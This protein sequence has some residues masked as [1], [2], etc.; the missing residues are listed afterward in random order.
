MAS[1]SDAIVVGSAVVNQIAKHG[2]SPELVERV[3]GFVKSL[4]AAV[5]DL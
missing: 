3:G 4:P 2:R 1:S 5:K